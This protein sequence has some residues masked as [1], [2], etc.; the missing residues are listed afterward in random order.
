MSDESGR[1]LEIPGRVSIVAGTN[2]LPKAIL[3]HHSGAQAEAYLHGA[4]ITSWKSPEGDP[5][6]FLSRESWFEPGKPIRGGIPVIFPQFSMQGPL[7]HHGIARNREWI[8]V[9][10]ETSESGTVLLQLRLAENA[11]TLGIWPFRFQFDLR[12]LLDERALTVEVEVANPDD[13]SFQFQLALHT[14][15]AVADIGR[16]A[17]VGM[18]GT[19]YIDSLR[20]RVREVEN[21]EEIRF[22]AETDRIYADT[23]N[24]LEVPHVHHREVRPARCG[25]LESVD[26]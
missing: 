8:P 20:D 17:V 13:E 21:R 23:R 15:F 22:E 18:S 6:F 26:R 1:G 12:L 19:E 7:P 14:Y 10:S 2:G 24:R 5:L 4:H 9:R 11:E 25:S 16:T 3:T